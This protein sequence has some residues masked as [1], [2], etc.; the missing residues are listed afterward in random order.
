MSLQKLIDKYGENNL[1]KSNWYS[2]SEGN[3][4]IPEELREYVDLKE[5]KLEIMEPIPE[6]LQPL[7][8]RLQESY[9]RAQDPEDLTE[10]RR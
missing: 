8:D 5:G 2:F 10:Y 3:I 4:R 7:V 6:E 9:R 1:D